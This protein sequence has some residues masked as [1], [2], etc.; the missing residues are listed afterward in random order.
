MNNRR[1]KDPEAEKLFSK[2]GD[3]K[4]SHWMETNC[5]PK[6]MFWVDMHILMKK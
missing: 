2:K 5:T 6:D 1:G 3:Q 4:P